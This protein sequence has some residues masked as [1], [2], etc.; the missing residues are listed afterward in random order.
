MGI[1]PLNFSIHFSELSLQKI[2]SR[3]LV[4]SSLFSS[5]ADKLIK[6]SS[7]ETGH[8]WFIKIK[9]SSKSWKE[10]HKKGGG[11]MYNYVCHAIYYLEFLFGKIISTKSNVVLDKENYLSS[12][13]NFETGLSAKINIKS[14]TKNSNRKPL[15]QLRIMSN[16]DNYLLKSKMI[17]LNF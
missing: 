11:I 2:L 14:L 5:R 8:Y 12:V 6:R 1:K 15:H 3:T 7:L 13:V 10:I 16:K 17:T 4:S 9:R